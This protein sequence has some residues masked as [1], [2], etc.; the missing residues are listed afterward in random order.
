MHDLATE[1]HPFP[2]A[3]PDRPVFV[4]TDL[5]QYAYCPR[6]VFYQ[7]CLPLV[8]SESYKMQASHKA[9][10]REQ[11]REVR[12]S[13]RRYGLDQGARA[14]DVDLYSASLGLRGRADLIITCPDE[15]IPVDYKLSRRK[16]GPHFRLQL[17]AYGLMLQEKTGLPAKRGFL[18][19]LLTRQ[20]ERVPLTANAYAKVRRTLDALRDMVERERMPDPP[21]G[22]AKCVGCEFRRFCND[23]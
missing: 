2:M 5:K 12:R 19:S 9:H 7:Y 8:C 22:R 20:A 6:V 10:D 14:F 17:A 18:Y 4:V 15:I 21:R 23:L 1:K 3:R 13:L 11:G 16:P